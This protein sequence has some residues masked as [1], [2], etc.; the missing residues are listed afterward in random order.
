[1]IRVYLLVASTFLLVA[2]GYGAW[3]HHVGWRDGRE[4]LEA[5]QAEEARAELDKKTQQQQKD[6]TK[7]AAADTAGAAKTVTI[8]QQVIKYV[9][10][11][12][13]TVCSF[14]NDRV[15]IKAGAAANA[16]YIPGFDAAP[17]SDADA[18]Q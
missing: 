12:G 17:V 11:P 6:D 4:A 7:A 5:S 15:R 16:N 18:K 1:M 3:Q 8:T 14:P 2:Y 9:K 13:H 10:T